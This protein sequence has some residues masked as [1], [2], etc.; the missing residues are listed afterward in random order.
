MTF[1]SQIDTI[2]RCLEVVINFHDNYYRFPLMIFNISWPTSEMK[3]FVN[4]FVG[5]S[6]DWISRFRKS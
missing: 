1:S 4:E 5:V 6:G 3:D 2:L